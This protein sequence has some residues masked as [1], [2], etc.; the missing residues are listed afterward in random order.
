MW[1]QA[2]DSPDLDVKV[3]ASLGTVLSGR[4]RYGK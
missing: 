4:G 1:T 3:F 2:I